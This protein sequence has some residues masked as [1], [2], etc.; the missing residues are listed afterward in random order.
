MLL[1]LLHKPHTQYLARLHEQLK[2][3]WSSLQRSWF[4]PSW[5][6]WQFH[7]R[8]PGKKIGMSQRKPTAR[9]MTQILFEGIEQ[10][11]RSFEAQLSRQYASQIGRLRHR[12]AHHVIGKH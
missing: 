10:L 2:R 11:Q 12:R 9:A 6:V 7:L 4:N 5:S 1:L 8:N 3:F